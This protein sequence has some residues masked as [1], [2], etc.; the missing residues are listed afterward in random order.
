MFELLNL[1][2][3]QIFKD[4]LEN[5]EL[6]DQSKFRFAESS[7][8]IGRRN[9][10]GNIRSNNELNKL[11]AN[12]ALGRDTAGVHWRS[13]GVEGIKPGEK[14]AITMLANY[15]LLTMKLLQDSRSEHLTAE[16][17]CRSTTNKTKF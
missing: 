1:G 13:D 12:I 11:A 4:Q 10:F 9:N 14:V 7:R 6:S 16:Y 17:S 15:K 8:A 3:F 2:L 5:T